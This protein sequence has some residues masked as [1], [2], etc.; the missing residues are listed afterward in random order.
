MRGV[1]FDAVEAGLLGARRRG[2]EGVHG[3]ADVH[4]RHRP[5]ND[6]LVGHLVDRMRD[7]GRRDRRLA[8][9]VEAG[10]AAA[11]A[12]LDRALA[13]AAMDFANE[14]RQARQELVVVD[15]ELAQP[16]PSGA[17]RRGHLDGD[18]ADAAAHP[19]HVVVDGVVGDVAVLVGE[20]RVVIGG[21]TIRFADLH[22]PDVAPASAGCS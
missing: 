9:D 18:E 20:P 2:G 11:V 13:A 6:G 17:L 22:R 1:D 8:A 7:G 21:M 5:G 4:H 14:P 10:V 15:A 19:R 12:K 16:M 3:V